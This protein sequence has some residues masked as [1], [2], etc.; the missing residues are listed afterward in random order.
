LNKNELNKD[1]DKLFEP[2]VS[3]AKLAAI[4]FHE[5]KEEGLKA[6]SDIGS[7]YE[8]VKKALIETIIE[9]EER[10]AKGKIEFFNKDVFPCSFVQ[11]EI[12]SFAHPAGPINCA[13]DEG[14]R[15]DCPGCPES[16]VTNWEECY[17][18]GLIRKG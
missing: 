12:R 13:W 5:N 18:G 15:R 7:I 3:K 6:V 2:L 16:Y 4:Q 17:Y 9:T 1:L 14:K 11:K 8:S 10:Q